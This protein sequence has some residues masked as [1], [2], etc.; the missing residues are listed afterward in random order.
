VRAAIGRLGLAVELRDVHADP[1][2]MRELVDATG[3]T[4]VPCLRIEDAPGRVRW[5]HESADIVR[6]LE[7]RVGSA[8]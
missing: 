3:R 2:R 1:A 6:F 4:T 5:M 7:T 8:A